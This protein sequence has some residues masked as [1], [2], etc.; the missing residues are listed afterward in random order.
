MIVGLGIDIVDISR[1]E[2]IAKRSPQ[3]ISRLPRVNGRSD[4]A[5]DLARDIAIYEALYKALPDAEKYDI[6]SYR[7]FTD[8]GGRQL[9]KY[10]G[11]NFIRKNDYKIF[12]SISHEAKLVIACVVLESS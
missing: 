1:I 10:M 12:V 6:E 4:S 2:E 11:A 8:P 9:V 7:L 5:Q 3:L